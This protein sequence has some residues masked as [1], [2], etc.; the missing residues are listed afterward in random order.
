[1]VKISR[2]EA[3]G[4]GHDMKVLLLKKLIIDFLLNL[5]DMTL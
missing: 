4:K 2:I 5:S 1:M 3:K